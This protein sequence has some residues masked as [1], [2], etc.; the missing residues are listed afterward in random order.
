VKP[1]NK[2]EPRQLKTGYSTEQFIVVKDGLKPG[3][4]VVTG[5]QYRL[6]AGTLVAINKGDGSGQPP[7]QQAAK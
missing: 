2:V 7:E 4:T 1:D 5:G 3:E 6:M